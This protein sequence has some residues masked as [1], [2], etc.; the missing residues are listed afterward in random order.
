MLWCDVID[1]RRTLYATKTQEGAHF[2]NSR[3][4]LLIVESGT[5]IRKG[6]PLRF[7]SIR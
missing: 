3:A 2:S 1:R 6:P 7:T 4:Q 5:T